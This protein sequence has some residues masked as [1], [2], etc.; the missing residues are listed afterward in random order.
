MH[1]TCR[2]LGDNNWAVF[3]KSGQQMTTI[4]RFSKLGDV[5]EWFDTWMG[6]FRSDI[7]GEVDTTG[8]EDLRVIPNYWESKK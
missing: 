4:V 6:S 1:F 8:Y 2:Y 7:C 5:Q 3:N